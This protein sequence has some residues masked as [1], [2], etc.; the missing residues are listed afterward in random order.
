MVTLIVKNDATLATASLQVPSQVTQ[1][2]LVELALEK[3]NLPQDQPASITVGG[4]PLRLHGA[5]LLEAGVSPLA[6]I[7]LVCTAL[8]GGM[9][10]ALNDSGDKDDTYQRLDQVA[11]EDD[12]NDT[13]L[14]GKKTT[15]RMKKQFTINQTE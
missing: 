11:A 2:Q 13:Q 3:L 4:K 14:V 6:T 1:E 7:S 8:P 12:D 9:N 15:Q 10:T 5:C